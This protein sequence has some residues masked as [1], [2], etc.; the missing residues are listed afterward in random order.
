MHEPLHELGAEL[1]SDVADVTDAEFAECGIPQVK[2]EWLRSQ[3][4]AAVRGGGGAAGSGAVR[5]PEGVPKEDE[6]DGV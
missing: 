3:A 2:G 5:I 6:D 4:Q 1:L